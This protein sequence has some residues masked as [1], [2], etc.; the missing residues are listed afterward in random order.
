MLADLNVFGIFLD[1]SLV[2]AL[3]AAVALG[4][5]R[6]LLIAIGLYR[7]LWHPALADLAIF[8]VIWAALARAISFLPPQVINLLG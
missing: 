6:R 1:A 5:L 2:T 4:L 8:V 7:W 3:V